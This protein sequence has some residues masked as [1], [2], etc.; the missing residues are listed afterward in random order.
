MA[1]L[2]VAV[3]LGSCGGDDPAAAIDG[4]GREAANVLL[5]VE[6]SAAMGEE[7]RLERVRDG[8]D[9]LIAELP[10]GDRVG[11]AGFSDQL[12]PVVPVLPVER[13]RAGLLDGA[14]KLSAGGPSMLYD[15]TV[16]GYGI[17]RELARRGRV[18]AVVVL[19]HSPDAGSA[20]RIARLRRLLAAG[21]R[22]RV[23]TVGYDSPDSSLHGALA[24]IARASGGRAH[25]A[26]SDDVEPV[27]RR[28]W[29]SL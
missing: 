22:V 8:L 7:N 4:G 26:G 6:S 16:E 25:S 1:A 20:T 13:N 27:L 24:L 9:E 14:E 19:A 28:I 18:N 21:S 17:V 5:V 3:V 29:A 23:F 11:L 15:A 10:P 2:A 12:H